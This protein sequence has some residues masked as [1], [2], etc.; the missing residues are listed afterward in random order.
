MIL[1]QRCV[2]LDGGAFR[3]WNG[4]SRFGGLRPGGLLRTG[5]CPGFLSLQLL[6]EVCGYDCVTHGIHD[7]VGGIGN[8]LGNAA[9][10][11]VDHALYALIGIAARITERRSLLPSAS[12]YPS[13]FP[14]CQ[15]AAPF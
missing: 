6:H 7:G 8:G 4:G 2:F 1:G 10:N 5:D 3:A 9:A 11:F 14:G 13:L 15:P 12:A